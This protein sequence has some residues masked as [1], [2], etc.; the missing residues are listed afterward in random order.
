MAVEAAVAGVDFGIL[1][2]RTAHER[3]Q[4][5]R[6][7]VDSIMARVVA[8]DPTLTHLEW[9][10]GNEYRHNRQLPPIEATAKQKARW[11]IQ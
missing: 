6:A 4:A 10:Q 1:N 2:G 9:E 8:Q 3:S 11:G 5:K 7:R